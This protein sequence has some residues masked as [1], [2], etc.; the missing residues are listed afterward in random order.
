MSQDFL[1]VNMIVIIKADGRTNFLESVNVKILFWVF[2][3]FCKYEFI[4]NV[5]FTKIILLVLSPFW[6]T[7]LPDTPSIFGIQVLSCEFSN[8]NYLQKAYYW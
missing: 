7:S 5:T 6:C 8:I 2:P 1:G 4:M 3:V